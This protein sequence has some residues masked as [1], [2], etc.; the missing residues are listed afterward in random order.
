LNHNALKGDTHY[1]SRHACTQNLGRK[2]LKHL[3]KKLIQISNEDATLDI[4]VNMLNYQIK[5]RHFCED[6]ITMNIHKMET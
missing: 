4:F 3:Q 6:S 1:H 2:K 5:N